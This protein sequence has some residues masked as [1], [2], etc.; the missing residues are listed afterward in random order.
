[1]LD[2]PNQLRIAADKLYQEL[3]GELSR[4]QA[5][6]AKATSSTLIAQLP[7]YFYAPQ[8]TVDG[9]SQALKNN[10][11]GY[12][13]SLCVTPNA[14]GIGAR[15]ISGEKDW[16][17]YLGHAQAARGFISSALSDLGSEGQF[18]SRFWDEVI[19]K[20]AVETTQV[21][22]T[23]YSDFTRLLPWAVVGVV[24]LAII[25]VIF[26]V[27]GLRAGGGGGGA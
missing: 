8:E 9:V 20:S 4:A 12:V 7:T 17:W 15:L 25:Y 3:V 24:A 23:G 11:A 2:D 27:R 5:R 18:F 22:K 21:A 19:V 10:V 1:M 14:G 16:G 6:L 26:S 13:H